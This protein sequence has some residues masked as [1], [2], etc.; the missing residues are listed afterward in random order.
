MSMVE[1]AKAHL[2]ALVEL[3]F[4]STRVKNTEYMVY[5]RLVTSASSHALG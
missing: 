4:V 1:L 5:G 3:D 2:V